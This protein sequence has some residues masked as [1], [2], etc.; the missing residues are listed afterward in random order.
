MLTRLPLY[1][2]PK[3]ALVSRS[4]GSITAK[5]AGPT[6]EGKLAP[7][8]S[9]ITQGRR[10]PLLPA[11]EGGIILLRHAG[12]DCHQVGRCRARPRA[13]SAPATG[14][15]RRPAVFQLRLL[16]TALVS[17]VDRSRGRTVRVINRGNRRRRVRLVFAATEGESLRPCSASRR[18]GSGWAQISHRLPTAGIA[19]SPMLA[20]VRRVS[21]GGV[22]RG[23]KKV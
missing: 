8:A 20:D 16:P 9:L 3:A 14:A 4:V 13:V 6:R 19:V 1:C 17:T 10:V 23:S 7:T 2:A 15:Q 5:I 22:R 18:G 21:G 12:R 11:K